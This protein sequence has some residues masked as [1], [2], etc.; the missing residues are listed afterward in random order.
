[1]AARKDTLF[2]ILSRQPWWVTLIVAFALYWVALWIFPPVAPFI[3]VPFV[4]LAG[5]IGYT[6]LR[7]GSPADAGERLAALRDMSWD[8]FSAAVTAGYRKQGYDVAPS[9][10]RG[11]DFRL[12]KGGRVTLL[13]CRQ[14]KVNQ[15]GVAPIRELA[16]AVERDDASRGICLAA[17]DF[18]APARKAASSEP[19]TLVSGEDLAE[20]VGRVGKKRSWFGR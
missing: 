12:T 4:V 1:M 13:Q 18:S 11:Y 15:V 20:L 10:G 16:K 7:S 6:Q 5:Y 9:E 17:G 8:E 19:V 14:W 3:T 2:H